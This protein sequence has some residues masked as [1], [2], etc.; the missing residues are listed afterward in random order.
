MT[1]LTFTL[2]WIMG[3]LVGLVIGELV[4]RPGKV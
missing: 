3:V 1:A 2:G 4:K